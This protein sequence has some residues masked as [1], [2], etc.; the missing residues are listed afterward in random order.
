MAIAIQDSIDV[1]LLTGTRWAAYRP[2]LRDSPIRGRLRGGNSNPHGTVLAHCRNYVSG[3]ASPEE[4]KKKIALVENE[5]KRKS[6]APASKTSSAFTP[7]PLE[8]W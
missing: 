2:D 7:P 1:G 8:R 6:S 4:I 3:K 5:D